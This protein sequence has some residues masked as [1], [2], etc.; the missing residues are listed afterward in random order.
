M[1]TREKLQTSLADFDSTPTTATACSKQ[2]LLLVIYYLIILFIILF[3]IIS[4]KIIYIYT[5]THNY[6]MQWIN[7]QNTKERDTPVSCYLA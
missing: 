4:L 3:I 1:I 7:W 6:N 5:N 2:T